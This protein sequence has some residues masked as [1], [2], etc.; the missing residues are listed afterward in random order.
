MPVVRAAQVLSISVIAIGMIQPAL[1]GEGPTPFS[2]WA[3][4]ETSGLLAWE[5]VN[6]YY[7]TYVGGP[8]LG[9]PGSLDP[10]HNTAVGFDGANDRVLA[11]GFGG[12]LNMGTDSFT[13]IV[14]FR[15][16]TDSPDWMK[17][18]N[19][20]LTVSGTPQNAGYGMRI[21][22][23]IIEFHVSDGSG[24]V[25]ALSTEPAQLG[26]HFVAGVLDR[27]A[28]EIRLHLDPTDANPTVFDTFASL[29]SLDTNIDFAI[30]ALDRSPVGNP[31]EF[32]EGWIDDVQLYREAL[33]G[34]QLLALYQE[35]PCQADLAAPFGVLDLADVLS[36][37][38]AFQAG[39]AVADLAAPC[40]TYD[41]T[42]V[43]AFVT[44]FLDG[45]F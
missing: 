31:S 39:D 1:G 18:I 44:V 34:D 38:A 20:G 8:T 33:T 43:T 41:L 14:R 13:V 40:G 21:R 35:Q 26:W 27:N 25:R 2:H 9:L 3:L 6:G 5:D 36:F 42:D 28:G 17:I 7:A 19:K 45:C 15:K 30:G 32:F 22:E 10:C 24:A 16:T 29:G 23:G 11:T 37:I 4:N 12:L